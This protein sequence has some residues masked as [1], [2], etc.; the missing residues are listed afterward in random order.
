MT[1]AANLTEEHRVREAMAPRVCPSSC[2]RRSDSVA[3][4]ATMGHRQLLD[5]D[6]S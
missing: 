4:L 3:V 6:W 2:Y 1:G 5:Y